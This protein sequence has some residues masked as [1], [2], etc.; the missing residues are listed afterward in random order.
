PTGLWA[1]KLGLS[2]QPAEKLGLGLDFFY[3]RA[4][5]VAAGISKTIGFEIDASA[6]YMITE[7]LSLS[8]D[9]SYF[10]RGGLIKDV[11]GTGTKNAWQAV[12]SIG[13]SF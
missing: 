13:L 11:L 12:A 2:A 7:D 8:G 4:N 9:L 5:E 3:L 1:T 6:K 10:M